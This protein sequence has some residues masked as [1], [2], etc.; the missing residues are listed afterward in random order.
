M[1]A[2]NVFV[3]YDDFEQQ[4]ALANVAAML[5][6]GGLF[7]SNDAPFPLPATP[8]ISSVSAS[9]I[10]YTDPPQEKEYLIAHQRK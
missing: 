7:L 2:T 4:L 6:P 8:L 1:V 5:R 3:Y 9:T 10:T